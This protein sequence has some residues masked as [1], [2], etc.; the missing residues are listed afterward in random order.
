MKL[1]GV[2]VVEG[3]QDSESKIRIKFVGLGRDI[4]LA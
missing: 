2:S 4:S 3:F 1:L